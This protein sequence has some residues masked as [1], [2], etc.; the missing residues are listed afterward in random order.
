MY[1]L[2][3]ILFY[4]ILLICIQ[5]CI[6]ISSKTQPAIFGTYIDLIVQFPGSEKKSI[7][8]MYNI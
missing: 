8:K 5:F 6:K 4:K 3:R 2:E 7:F 1:I